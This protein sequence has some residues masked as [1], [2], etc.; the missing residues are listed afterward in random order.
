MEEIIFYYYNNNI[1]NIIRRQK[2]VLD[3]LMTESQSHIWDGTKQELPEYEICISLEKL[4]LQNLKDYSF[5]RWQKSN[6][7]STIRKIKTLL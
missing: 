7:K 2:F 5:K 6:P 3:D 1:N 4:P